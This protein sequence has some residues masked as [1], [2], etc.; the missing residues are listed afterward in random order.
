MADIEGTARVLVLVEAPA[1]AGS[2]AGTGDPVA[3]VPGL[4][5]ASLKML[6]QDAR[7]RKQARV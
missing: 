1:V 5:R 6:A 2:R 3:A 7:P 4:L